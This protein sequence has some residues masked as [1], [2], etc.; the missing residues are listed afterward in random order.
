[1]PKMNDKGEEQMYF[2]NVEALKE[3]YVSEEMGQRREWLVFLGCESH[4]QLKELT[5][6]CNENNVELIGGIYSG[7]LVNEKNIKNGF[8][9][10]EINTVHKVKVL[11]HLMKSCKLDP[12]RTGNI[13]I[14][15]ADG[16]SPHFK[17]L[18]DTL[19]EKLEKNVTYVGGGAGFYDYGAQTL[20]I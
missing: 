13:A 14:V 10:V 4:H 19:Y 20:C 7:L 6:F 3:K 18:M 16:L 8:I 9:V 17:V 11:P 1:M 15:L 2:A 5:L 12:D